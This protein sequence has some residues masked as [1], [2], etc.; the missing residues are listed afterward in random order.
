MQHCGMPTCRFTCMAANTALPLVCAV[1]ATRQR[2][3]APP[4]ARVHATETLRL[5]I[6]SA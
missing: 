1:A 6:A 4:A 5:F 2:E 3:A